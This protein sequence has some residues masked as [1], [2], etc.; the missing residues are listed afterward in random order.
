MAR[1]RD[2]PDREAARRRRSAPCASGG[3]TA[4][5][6]GDNDGV[7]VLARCLAS[8]RCDEPS[9]R[10]SDR[11]S[12]RIRDGDAI[13][14]SLLGGQPRTLDVQGRATW[15]AN[16]DLGAVRAT[17]SCRATVV[18]DVAAMPTLN[19]AAQT[20]SIYFNDVLIGA[21]LLNANGKPQRITAH[22]P[23]YALAP[24]NLLRVVFQ[25]QPEGGCQA[26]G[27]AIR[28]PCCRPAI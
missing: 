14:L 7:A 6:V 9:G 18:L 20:A 8:D 4:I 5:V 17:V 23:H 24:G 25:R 10:A 21:Q 2:R 11:H 15:D 12:R 13:A 27:K 26:R 22:V 3:Q 1:P 19:G 16:F 28:L